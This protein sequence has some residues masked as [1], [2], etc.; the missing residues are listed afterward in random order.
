MDDLI[1]QLY[2]DNSNEASDDLEKIAGPEAVHILGEL[3]KE[4][5][6]QGIDLSQYSDDD[7]AEL[8]LETMGGYEDEGSVKVASAY[9]QGPD[10]PYDVDMEKVAAAEFLGRVQ[11]HAMAEEFAGIFGMEFEKQASVHDID[12]AQ[13]EE[14]A[15]L[16][17][18]DILEAIGALENPQDIA[19]AEGRE[20]VA[21]IPMDDELNE[22][23]GA[24]SAEMLDEAGWDVDAI[25]GI[26]SGE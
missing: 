2:A 22:L 25:A 17:A 20:K 12:E 24:R 10:L 1:S 14:L 13:F 3:E 5:A 11:A 19:E 15:A 4:A 9:E 6:A 16:H 8:I 18:N 26:L 7:I 23:I 21:S